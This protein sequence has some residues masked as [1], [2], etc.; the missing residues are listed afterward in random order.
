MTA[1]DEYAIQTINEVERLLN[2]RPIKKF[3][4]NN[5]FEKLK[6][7]GVALMG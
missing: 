2:Y 3:N 4:Y 6:N 7:K 1:Y 5:S